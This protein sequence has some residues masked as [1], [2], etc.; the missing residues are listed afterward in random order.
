[1]APSVEPA[2][3]ASSCWNAHVASQIEELKKRRLNAAK[4]STAVAAVSDSDMFKAPPITKLRAKDMSS[5]F[6]QESKS[7]QPAILKKAAAHIKRPG[8]I[9]LG[10]GLPSSEHFPISEI[11]MRVPKPPAFKE[12]DFSSTDAGL[13]AR[14]GK[15]D[16]REGRSEYDLAIALNYAQATGGGQMLRFITEHTELIF[17]PLYADWQVCQTVGTTGAFEQV[18]RMLFEKGKNSLITD[19]FAYT[20]ALETV[21][22]QG[23]RVFGVKMDE[24]GLIPEALEEALASWDELTRGAP[25]PHV[26]FLNPS[27]QNPTGATQ[28]FRRRRDIYQVCQRH[29]LLIIEDEPYYFIQMDPYTG[30]DSPTWAT[31]TASIDEFVAGLV[32]SYL[33]IDTDGRVIRMDSFSKVLVP[34]ARLGWITGSQQV[35]ERYIRHSECANQGPSGFSQLMLWK[36]LDETWGHEGYLRWLIDL[37]TSYTRR[38]NTLLAACEDHLPSG[39]VSWTPPEAGMFMWLTVD[40]TQHP[41]YEQR[42]ILEIEQEIY[43]LAVATGVLVSCGSW[44]RAEQEKPVRNLC[45]RITYATASEEAMTIA[46]QRLSASICKSFKRN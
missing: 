5:H 42:G 16:A 41:D 20:A 30:R 17:K 44:F 13:V 26:L 14:I 32:P 25:K 3:P 45:F 22:P 2:L 43:Q 36:L 9:S 19:E 11:T 33:S 34:G 15:Y 46:I 12:E 7:R 31:N 38:R 37:K 8:M 29:D 40:H 28:S 21:A 35:I 23:V 1:M 6:T 4:I 24:Q 39:L 27:G 18:A 10:G